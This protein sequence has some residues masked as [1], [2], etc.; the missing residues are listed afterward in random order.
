MVTMKYHPGSVKIDLS[1]IQLTKIVILFRVNSKTGVS[2][3]QWQNYL[4]QNYIKTIFVL[5]N[6]ILDLRMASETVIVHSF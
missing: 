2:Q 5:V 3:K 4:G 1:V 6:L